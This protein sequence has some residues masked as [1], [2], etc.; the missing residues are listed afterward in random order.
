MYAW[1]IG[2]RLWRTWVRRL[3]LLAALFVASPLAG[4]QAIAQVCSTDAQ[5]GPSAGGY[6]VCLG[7]TLVI[8]QRL[9]VGGQCLEQETGRV[10][11]GSG[12]IGGTCMGNVYV[13]S[14]GNRCD[15]MSGRCVQGSAVR[16]TCM[17]SCSCVG[18]TLTIGTGTCSTGVG[19]VRTA[20]VCK[21]GCTCSP[22]PRCTDEPTRGQP[23]AAAP[24]A[25][26]APK[27]NKLPMRMAEPF[28][29]NAPRAADSAAVSEPVEA[30]RPIKKK[31]RV[32]R[33]R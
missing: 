1:A 8:R 21:V 14:G 31:K 13:G 22:E 16:E 3:L 32:R 6:N 20:L 24:G 18:R 28:D 10:S 19:C 5:C 4:T 27:V 29:P 23:R 17:R 15:A 2:V 25:K 9:C 12:R 33:A 11:C 30:A 26:P 7:D